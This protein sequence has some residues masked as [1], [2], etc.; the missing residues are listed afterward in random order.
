M[1]QP[2][3]LAKLW[4]WTGIATLIAI[5]TFGMGFAAIVHGPAGSLILPHLAK[6]TS[7]IPAVSFWVG[8]LPASKV[9]GGI[10]SSLVIV[11]PCFLSFIAATARMNHHRA[12]LA[13]E[14]KARELRD[15]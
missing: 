8:I 3:R 2:I 12:M 7:G 1:K 5:P 15:L 14:N 4:K 9:L 10:P 6:S 13:E 11:F